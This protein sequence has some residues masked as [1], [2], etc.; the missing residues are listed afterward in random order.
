[1]PRSR[2]RLKSHASVKST[3]F[4]ILSIMFTPVFKSHERDLVRSGG[5]KLYCVNDAFGFVSGAVCPVD[6]FIV[7]VASG[8]FK[9]GAAL[10]QRGFVAMDRSWVCHLL[11]LGLLPYDILVIA[12]STD[13]V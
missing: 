5:E 7:C 13:A 3:G 9:H 12:E 10:R 8:P 11:P 1:M 6:P 4:F 2:K